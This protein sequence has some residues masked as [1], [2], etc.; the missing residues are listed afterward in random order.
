MFVRQKYDNMDVKPE[1]RK[2]AMNNALYPRIAVR[3]TPLILEELRL[4]AEQRE[5]SI[6]VIVKEAIIAYLEEKA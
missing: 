4:L 6:S 2:K 1:R 3:V 5:V